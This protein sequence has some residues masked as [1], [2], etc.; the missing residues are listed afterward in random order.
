VSGAVTDSCQV[1]DSPIGSSV[2]S[3]PRNRVL[4]SFGVC[5]VCPTP[6]NFSV[7]D[8]GAKFALLKSTPH[9]LR[10]TTGYLVENSQLVHQLMYDIEGNKF[11][12]E[13]FCRPDGRHFARTVF[14]PQDVIISDGFNLEEALL[15]HQDLLPLAV[16]SRQMHFS[17]RLIN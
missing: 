10:G 6:E 3:L 13:V 16:N 5:S 2:I 11:L 15:K 17:S 1:R 12:I 7:Y 4:A 8:V 9:S 14:S